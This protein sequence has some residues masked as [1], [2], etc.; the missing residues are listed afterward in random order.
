MCCRHCCRAD[1]WIA[2][3][4]I[5]HLLANDDRDAR[6]DPI[7]ESRS[8]RRPRCRA[9][10]TRSSQTL[11]AGHKQPAAF[12]AAEIVDAAIAATRRSATIRP[13]WCWRCARGPTVTTARSGRPGRARRFALKVANTAWTDTGYR[14]VGAAVNGNAAEVLRHSTGIE[15]HT[16][17]RWLT[18]LDTADHPL[19][20]VWTAFVVDEASTVSTRDLHRVLGHIRRSDATLWMFGD[21]LQHGA[22]EAAGGS[23]HLVDRDPELT[24]T[25]TVIDASRDP[26]PRPASWAGPH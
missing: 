14:V 15:T 13:T 4:G 6:R 25:L 18:R 8:T 19:L 17:A 21:P 16:L 7:L 5:V 20:D 11:E 9:S 23:P 10:K 12:V 26:R 3:P 22:V 24:P 2:A 1:K